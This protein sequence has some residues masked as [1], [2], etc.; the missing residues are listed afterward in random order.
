M[1][2]GGGPTKRKASDCCCLCPPHK[3][4]ILGLLLV[5]LIPSGLPVGSCCLWPHIYVGVWDV[6]TNYHV[7]SVVVCVVPKAVSTNKCLPHPTPS[8]VIAKLFSH[9]SYLNGKNLIR[10]YNPGKRACQLV[11]VSRGCL[12]RSCPLGRRRALKQVRGGRPPLEVDG[13]RCVERAPAGR[14]GRVPRLCLL[15]VPQFVQQ[16]GASPFGTCGAER[17]RARL[18]WR[19]PR[20]QHTVFSSHGLRVATNSFDPMDVCVSQAD[21]GVTEDCSSTS[22]F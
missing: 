7:P 8:W 4:C 5:C 11:L 21:V 12:S 19:C 13:R 3:T 16:Q 17:R 14:Q 20:R 15:V 1:V 2:N 9:D 22:C 6:A 18:L 10:G